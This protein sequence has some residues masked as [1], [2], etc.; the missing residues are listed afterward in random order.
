[1]KTWRIA[2]CLW[3]LF[4]LHSNA[5]LAGAAGDLFERYSLAG[6]PTVQVVVEDFPQRLAPTLR[7]EELKVTIS[8]QLQTVGIPVASQAENALYVSLEAIAAGQQ[9][10]TYVLSLE[11]LQLVLLFRD[12]NIDTWGTTWSLRTMDTFFPD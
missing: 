9:Q 11:F 4:V 3:T 10:F 5:S 2:T 6:Q 8:Q 1:M 7:Q 12:P